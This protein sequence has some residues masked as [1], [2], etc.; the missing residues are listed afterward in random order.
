MKYISSLWGITN[1]YIINYKEIFLSLPY[2]VKIGVL[3]ATF[4]YE[5]NLDLLF[6]LLFPWLWFFIGD[7]IFYSFIIGSFIK[8]DVLIISFDKY[9]FVDSFWI[10]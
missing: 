8:R 3:G 1:I 7:T 6:Y 4:E 9:F 5:I 10:E 2:L